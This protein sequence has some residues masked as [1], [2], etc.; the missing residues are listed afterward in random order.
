MLRIVLATAA[1]L[2]AGCGSRPV[3]PSLIDAAREGRVDLISSLVKQ[4]A[5]PNQ[6]AGVNGWPP[7]M[8][9]I[10]KNQKGSVVALL[11]AGADVNARGDGGLT[12][13]MMAAGYGYT[14]IVNILLDRGA[15]PHA[16]LPNGE[17]ALTLA[18]FGLADIDRFTVPD[19]QVSMVK[20]LLQKAPDIRF[21]GPGG[22]LRA[23][24]IAKMKGCAGL[25]EAMGR[26]NR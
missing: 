2:L 18:V 24:T 8:H 16:Q 20:A 12:A 10:H 5:D 1:L 25:A 23:V 7:L 17:N 21:I 15:D 6:R 22:V 4:G 13:L 19:C 9:A 26:T 14:D 11:D 3:M